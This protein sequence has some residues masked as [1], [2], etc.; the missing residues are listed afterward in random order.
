M[1]EQRSSSRSFLSKRGLWAFLGIVLVL[2]VASIIV[3]ALLGPA[4]GNVFSTVNHSLTMSSPSSDTGSGKLASQQLTER[5]IIREGNISIVVEDTLAA[6]GSIERLVAEMA[7]EDAFV[8]SSTELGG[9]A[10]RSPRITM[11]LRVPSTRFGEVMDRLAALAVEVQ[12]RTETAQDVTEE[13]VDLQARLESLETA[14]AR[15]L[16]IME[17]AETTEDLLQ[18]EQQLTQ[19]EA[20]IESLKGRVEYLTQSARLSRIS[21]TLSPDVLSQPIE[22]R[23]RPAETAREA[24]EALVNSL[25][26]F[27]RFLIY[28]SIAILPWLV[29]LGLI[30]FAAVRFVR[31]R[32]PAHPDTETG[33]PPSQAE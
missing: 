1:T 6:K 7:S 2:V 18:A 23:W 30:G 32:R 9:T 5:L 29:L 31:R 17:D 26:G 27:G 12:E 8:V 24:F 10:D 11:V 3:L 28:F 19:R 13:Y 16:S 4:V 14:R 21:V 25:Q 15:L 33:E 20:E 22:G